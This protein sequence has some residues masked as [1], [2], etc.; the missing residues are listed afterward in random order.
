MMTASFSAGTPPRIGR[1]H[2]LFEFNPSE[3]TFACIPLRCYDVA[4]DGERFYAVQQRT[5]PASPV[6]NHLNLALN[7]FE[8]LESKVP[9]K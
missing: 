7:W 1:P 9:V 2:S 4:P 6:V 3:L 5:P 8:E